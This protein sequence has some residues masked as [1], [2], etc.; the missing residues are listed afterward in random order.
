MKFSTQ[1]KPISYLKS[2]AAEI[3]KDIT[4]NREPMLI[5]QNGEAK[6]VVMDVKSFEEQEETLA[7]LKILALGNREI[8]R[9]KFRDAEDVFAEMDEDDR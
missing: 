9:G 7:L 4:E 2:H 5:T 3:I 6:L 8:E 1:V